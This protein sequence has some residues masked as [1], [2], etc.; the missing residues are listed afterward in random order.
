MGPDEIRGPQRQGL[1]YMFALLAWHMFDLLVC[2]ILM[3]SVEL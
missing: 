1:A 3:G 2:L